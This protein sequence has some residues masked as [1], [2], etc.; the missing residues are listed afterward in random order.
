MSGG[1][2]RADYQAAQAKAEAARAGVELARTGKR[3][4]ASVG[5]TYEREHSEDAGYGMR[6]E[7]F[8][9]LKFSLPLPLWNKQ[10]GKVTEASAAALRAAR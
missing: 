2:A 5:L 4:D 9:G 10:K 7:N 8:I 3:A 1:S 6:R